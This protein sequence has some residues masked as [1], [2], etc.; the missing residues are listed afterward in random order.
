MNTTPDKTFSNA[1]SR[2]PGYTHVQT[3]REDV[4]EIWESSSIMSLTVNGEVPGPF[5]WLSVLS[6]LVPDQAS[7]AHLSVDD[8]IA[9]R[10]GLTAWLRSVK[11]D[12]TEHQP[13]ASDIDALAQE[14]RRV[15]GAHTLGA[16]ALAEALAPLLARVRTEERERAARIV[17]D[18]NWALGPIA[19][20]IRE[21]AS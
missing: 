11:E 5:V 2:L 14:I 13:S 12:P 19:T 7:P 20:K 8:A 15:D 9:V 17:L 18:D 10:D 16:G 1:R 3:A 6:A 21:Q 4:V